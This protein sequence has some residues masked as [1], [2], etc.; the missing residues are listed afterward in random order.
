MCDCAQKTETEEQSKA[1]ETAVGG[2]YKSLVRL[3]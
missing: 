3:F 1:A 2:Q